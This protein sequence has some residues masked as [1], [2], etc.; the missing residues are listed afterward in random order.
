MDEMDADLGFQPMHAD[1]M[2]TSGQVSRAAFENEEKSTLKAA[3]DGAAAMFKQVKNLVPMNI[4]GMPGKAVDAVTD[5]AKDAF[6]LPSFMSMMA[7]ANPSSFSK[8]GSV[9]EAAKRLRQNLLIYKRNYISTG[10]L[11]FLLKFITS[12]TLFVPMLLVGAVWVWLLSTKENPEPVSFGPI[13]LNKRNKCIALAIPTFAFTWWMASSALVWCAILA[14]CIAVL[15]GVFHTA[16]AHMKAMAQ[17]KIQE[18]VTSSGQIPMHNN[19]IPNIDPLDTN[20]VDE[21]WWDLQ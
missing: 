12:P 8:P 19:S 20:A 18:A 6:K 5:Q 7:F 15:H 1:D 10:V 4:S 11:L 2:D 13:Q 17:A 21:E 3:K 9:A 16:P 14:G